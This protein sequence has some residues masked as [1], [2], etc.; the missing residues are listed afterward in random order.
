MLIPPFSD[1]LVNPLLPS[2]LLV[3][4]NSQKHGPHSP[5]TS[6]KASLRRF[7]KAMPFSVYFFQRILWSC[8][9]RFFFPKVTIQSS[10]ILDHKAYLSDRP[11]QSC[12]TRLTKPAKVKAYFRWYIVTLNMFAGRYRKGN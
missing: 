4:T 2:V 12:I 7:T 8:N 1:A 5:T 6:L 10:L 11:E 3:L 9:L